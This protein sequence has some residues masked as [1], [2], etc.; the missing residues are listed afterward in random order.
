MIRE[1]LLKQNTLMS[2]IGVFNEGCAEIEFLA[3]QASDALEQLNDNVFPAHLLG[4]DKVCSTLE[5][6][7]EGFDIKE[8]A[9]HKAGFSNNV[10]VLQPVHMMAVTPMHKIAYQDLVL[11]GGDQNLPFVKN[12]ETSSFMLIDWEFTKPTHPV[13]SVID[14]YIECKHALEEQKVPQIIKAVI[15][16][17][18]LILL[19]LYN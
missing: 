3:Q 15:F 4:P 18:S 10:Q 14:F 12:T 7:I 2:W 6:S 13:C 1:D 8:C 9:G 17:Q 11:K 5:I 16:S 19:S